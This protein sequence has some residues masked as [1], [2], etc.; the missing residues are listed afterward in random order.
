VQHLDGT[1]HMH[2]G[3]TERQLKNVRSSI[4]RVIFEDGEP[5]NLTTLA[6][7]RTRLHG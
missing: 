2:D 5:K 6:E 1:I 4:M 7:I 3:L